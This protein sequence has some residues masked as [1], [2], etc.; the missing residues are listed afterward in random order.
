[1]LCTFT[2][3]NSLAVFPSFFLRPLF[4]ETMMKIGCPLQYMT[5]IVIKRQKLLSATYHTAV[6]Y[7]AKNK[8]VAKTE[9]KEIEILDKKTDSQLGK[10]EISDDIMKPPP[11]DEE[12]PNPRDI[13]NRMDMREIPKQF[14]VSTISKNFTMKAEMIFQSLASQ[15]KNIQTFKKATELYLEKEGVYHR[16]MVEFNL[17][18]LNKLAE[19]NVLWDLNAYKALMNVFPKERLKPQGFWQAELMHYPKQQ[20]CA[21]TIIDTM[22]MNGKVILRYIVLYLYNLKLHAIKQTF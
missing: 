3:Y 22:E 19:Y 17:V 2:Y 21:I 4:K 16:G 12:L 11:I 5:R 7:Y 1:M 15:P 18:A 10:Y 9:T 6:S 8:E 20:D 14:H 13:T